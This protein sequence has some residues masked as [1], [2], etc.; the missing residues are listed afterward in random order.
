MPDSPHFLLSLDPSIYLKPRALSFEVPPRPAQVSF[1]FV[2]MA[3]RLP[4]PHPTLCGFY[5]HTHTDPFH[6]VLSNFAPFSV[7]H[8][9]KPIPT[10]ITQM[11]THLGYGIPALLSTHPGS[12]G[13]QSKVRMTTGSTR[14]GLRT[15]SLAELPW[16]GSS[17]SGKGG[18]ASDKEEGK[19]SSKRCLWVVPGGL[20]LQGRGLPRVFWN[21]LNI[22]MDRSA[23]SYEQC[24][25]HSK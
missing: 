18:V 11:F 16:E 2:L 6:L 20:A 9:P 24:L 3:L 22:S 23:A 12:G 13:I 5:K 19:P 10:T 7:K 17:S 1:R 15:S 14:R 25:A 21:L 8:S 4:G